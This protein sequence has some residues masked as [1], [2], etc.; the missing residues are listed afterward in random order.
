MAA[1]SNRVQPVHPGTIPP[2][3]TH[4][5]RKILSE[6]ATPTDHR[7]GAYTDVLMNPAEAPD[8]GIVSDRDMSGQGGR[9]RHNQMI[10]QPTI[11][12]HVDIGHQKILIPDGRHTASLHRPSIDC[13]IFAENIVV[14]Y[15]D[16][17][18]L[19]GV[20]QMLWRTPDRRK[21]VQVA[22]FSNLSPSIH[23]H[24][25]DKFGSFAD[26]D[27][28]ADHAIRPHYHVISQLRLRVHN[29]TRMN[30]HL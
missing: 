9:V 29:G 27:V 16:L 4:E 21:W 20:P 12:S 15:H 5:G 24:M 7:I 8:D 28:L 17:G 6:G 10:T 19:A 26:L 25:G 18:R 11:V 1:Q 14:A 13:D 23:A 2:G 3:R 22:A 30:L